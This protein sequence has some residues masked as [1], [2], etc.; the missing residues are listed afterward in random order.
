[1]TEGVLEGFP[2]GFVVGDAVGLYEGSNVR[3][4]VDFTVGTHDGMADGAASI[5]TPNIKQR[6]AIM[7]HKDVIVRDDY[8]QLIFYFFTLLQSLLQ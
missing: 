1:M 3:L 8:L 6:S 4:L 7:V 2:E 5:G